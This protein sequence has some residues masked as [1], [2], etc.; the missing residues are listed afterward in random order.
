MSKNKTFE[1]FLEQL[2]CSHTSYDDLAEMFYIIRSEMVREK[3]TKGN[4]SNTSEDSL[5][6]KLKKENIRLR[7]LC[8]RAA[9]EIRDLDRMIIKSIEDNKVIEY[10]EEDKAYFAGFSSINLL[11]RLDGITSGGYVENYDDLNLEMKILA[12]HYQFDHPDF[13]QAAEQVIDDHKETLQK[14][15]DN[16]YPYKHLKEECV[17]YQEGGMGCPDCY[18]DSSCKDDSCHICGGN[19][20]ERV[21]EQTKWLEK[22]A[23]Q[24]EE[25]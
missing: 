12:G 20:Q 2:H 3:E 14:L 8:R 4:H 24:K 19:T 15:A 23:K 18:C 9:E 11:N 13:Y 7:S 21:E 22:I 1:D 25:K 6:L 17:A 16:P 10:P 5:L